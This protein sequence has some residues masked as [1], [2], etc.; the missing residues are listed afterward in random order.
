MIDHMKRNCAMIIKKI[1]Q[2]YYYLLLHKISIQH[3][4]LLI[5]PFNNYRRHI[6]ANGFFFLVNN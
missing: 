2:L 6:D 3:G 4:N 5:V 1:L